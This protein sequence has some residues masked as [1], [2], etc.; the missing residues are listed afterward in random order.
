MRQIKPYRRRWDVIFAIGSIVA[1]CM[2]GLILGAL[3]EGISVE[4]IAFSG[5]VFDCFRP[6][7]AA[8]RP[9]RT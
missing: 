1:A 5:S 2:Q 6:F 4:G 3:I 9:L 8:L 7:P